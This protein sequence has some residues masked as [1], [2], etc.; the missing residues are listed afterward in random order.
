[1]EVGRPFVC[2]V[3]TGLDWHVH[4]L[5]GRLS[6]ILHV[7]MSGQ[8]FAAHAQAP[9]DADEHLSRLYDGHE[10]G[11][12]GGADAPDHGQDDPED[13]VACTRYPR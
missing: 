12:K 11:N 13:E 4:R 7:I 2:C 3:I 5:E 1:M 8:S 9:E 6:R 10:G